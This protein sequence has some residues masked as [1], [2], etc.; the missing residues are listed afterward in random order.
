ML[1]Y[2]RCCSASGACISRHASWRSA[3][4]LRVRRWLCVLC[5]TMAVPGP[6]AVMGEAEEGEGL[7]TPLATL[8]SGH[9]RKPAKRDQPRLVLVHRQAE[10]GQPILEVDH[11][12]PGIARALEAHHEV[13]GIPD[14]RDPTA[15]VPA[16]PL[17]DPEIKDVMQEDVGQERADAGSL[18]R[19]P[20]RLVPLIALQNAGFEPLADEPQDSR[21]GDPVRQHP[22]QP[23]V[24]NRVEGSGGRLPIAVIFRIR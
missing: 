18:R 23:L 5:F 12:P 24:V 17:M 22:Q 21:I 3:F 14:D 4:S 1:E 7:R 2:Q 9:G 8:L 16:A 11:H 10:L 19:S 15:S 6:P 20:V 13:V